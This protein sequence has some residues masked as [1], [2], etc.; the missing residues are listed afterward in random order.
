M[1]VTIKQFGPIENIELEIK[2]MTVLTGFQSSGKSTI[3]KTIY[4]FRTLKDKIADFIPNNTEEYK[5]NISLDDITVTPVRKTK[6]HMLEI[7]QR[8]A[9]DFSILAVSILENVV[10]CCKV[11]SLVRQGR[12][13]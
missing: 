8:D 6:V 5:K 4:F 13:I 12:I 7:I 10:S 9:K 1:K 2:D 11:G 3:A